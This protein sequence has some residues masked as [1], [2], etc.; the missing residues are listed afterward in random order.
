MKTNRQAR[1][2]RASF[3]VF[4]CR[5]ALN[6][7]SEKKIYG[8]QFVYRPSHPGPR[9][10]PIDCAL[11]GG[12]LGAPRQR[13]AHRGFPRRTPA[14]GCTKTAEKQAGKTGW[15]RFVRR[16]A[17][18]LPIF[19]RLYPA[20]ISYLMKKNRGFRGP[21]FRTEVRT[22]PNHSVPRRFDRLVVSFIDSASRTNINLAGRLD[23]AEGLIFWARPKLGELTH[24]LVVQM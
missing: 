15:R 14:C 13:R 12:T 9:F 11:G 24:H 17:V 5:K 6:G 7:Q 2:L 8:P 4:V 16:F 3:C 21:R 23:G 22:D 10:N 1:I 20:Q 19:S 18:N